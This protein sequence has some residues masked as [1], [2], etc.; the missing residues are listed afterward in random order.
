M[1]WFSFRISIINN[2]NLTCF[3]ESVNYEY[4]DEVKPRVDTFY[5]VMFRSGHVIF[6]VFI[7]LIRL[8]FHIK[9]TYLISIFS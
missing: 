6:F 8:E 4:Q 3:S 9:D 7:I 2:C 5:H 1:D